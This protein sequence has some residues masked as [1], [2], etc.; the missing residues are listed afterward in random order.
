MLDTTQGSSACQ[1]CNN[2]EPKPGHSF[3]S[4]EYADLLQ[5]PGQERCLTCWCVHNALKQYGCGSVIGQ[6]HFSARPGSV[7]FAAWVEAG[8]N[9]TSRGRAVEIFRQSEQDTAGSNQVSSAS[10]TDLPASIILELGTANHIAPEPT[11]VSIQS[12]ITSWLKTC[13]EQHPE[14][15]V[16]VTDYP[17]RLLDLGD[18]GSESIRLVEGLKSVRYTALSHRWGDTTWCTTTNANL[19]DRLLRIEMGDLARTFQDA[20]T[21]TRQLGI[22]YIWIDSLCILQDDLYDWAKESVK[23]GGI[24][25]GAYVT[26]AASLASSD[27]EGFLTPRRERK[28]YSAS[29][30]ELD[31]GGK[32][33]SDIWIRTV[34]DLRQHSF[35][36]IRES[37]STRCW[38]MQERMLSSRLISYTSAVTFDCATL[39][40]CECGHDLYPNPLYP[41]I[42]RLLGVD[43]KMAFLELLRPESQSMRRMYI[44]WADIVTVYSGRQLTYEKDRQIALSAVAKLLAKRYNEEYVAGLWKGNMIS[45]LSWHSDDNSPIIKPLGQD[46]PYPSWSWMSAHRLVMHN[47]ITPAPSCKV[48]L[49]DVQHG[50]L[51]DSGPAQGCIKL[52][53]SVGKMVLHMSKTF[54]SSNTQSDIPPVELRGP[55]GE[56]VTDYKVR[57]MKMDD[58]IEPCTAVDASGNQFISA[59]RGGPHE[60]QFQSTVICLHTGWYTMYDNSRAEVFLILGASERPGAYQRI[61]MVYANIT[62]EVL[63]SWLGNGQYE[64]VAIF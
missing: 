21:V 47:N 26:I 56:L 48:L 6:V 62:D 36:D 25:R 60:G 27:D 37:L 19:P 31:F 15:R 59:K 64:E 4:L 13:D 18:P 32:S 22:Q 11:G 8:E 49:I 40:A 24:Y 20:V 16:D 3:W 23:M 61:G 28:V 35:H 52:Q 12:S 54:Q 55:T 17:A 9:S 41:P 50:G 44:V 39:S 63:K 1:L 10:P 30:V 29:R 42:N 14:C 58:W 57:G 51:D 38:T 34:H 7:I 45:G 43:N 33:F 5:N 46:I 2:L 53:A